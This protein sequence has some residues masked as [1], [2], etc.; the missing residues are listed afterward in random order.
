MRTPRLR[1]SVCILPSIW[2]G[3]SPLCRLGKVKQWPCGKLGCDLLEQ[4]QLPAWLPGL[5]NL[6]P[7]KIWG[8]LSHVHWQTYGY[9][10]GGACICGVITAGLTHGVATSWL[11]CQ[12][13]ATE[14]YSVPSCF[15]NGGVPE[16][17]LAVRL[18]ASATA[19]PQ[20]H[21]PFLL[22]LWLLWLSC[23]NYSFSSEEA[24]GVRSCSSKCHLTLML[25]CYST[26][27]G[28]G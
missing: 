25:W 6:I 21:H 9:L 15:V 18:G 5:R 11:P 7:W 10:R 13:L 8:S 1:H 12:K 19:G 26:H 3:Y 4:Q 2:V 22:L 20:Q 28:S 27:V 23:S 16:P 17:E 24:K 14:L